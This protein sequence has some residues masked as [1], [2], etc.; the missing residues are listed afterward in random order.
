MASSRK[1]PKNSTLLAR[2]S[3]TIKRHV[4]RGGHLAAG[5]SGGI[6]SVV[7]L[8]L[9]CRASRRGAF[10]LS[11]LH[12]NHQIHPAADAWARFC[13]RLCRTLGVALRV[14]KVAVRRGNSLEAAARSARYAAFAGSKADAIVLAHNQDDQ[15]ETLLLQLLRGSGVKG[16]SAM[17][18]FRPEKPALLRPLLDVPRSEIAAY[19][20]ARKLAWIEDDSN[21]DVAFDRN[22][23]RHCVMPVLAARFPAY[24]RTLARASRHF[25]EATL[26]ADACA[27]ADAGDCAQTLDVRRLHGLSPAR[28]KNALRYFLAQH[29]VLMP[30]AR[31]L[32]ECARQALLGG[33]RMRLRL[34]EVELRRVADRLHVVGADGAPVAFVPRQWRGE[35]ALRLP[36]LGGVLCMT[37]CRGGGLSLV[38][39][40]GAAVTLR[41]RAGGE[42]LRPVAGR[43]RRTLKNLWQEARVP[44]WLRARVPLLFVGDELA[45]VPGLGI[46][47]AFQAGHAERGLM[48]DWRPDPG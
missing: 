27:A 8:D 28:V 30:N 2:V 22:Y 31:R 41:L 7:L 46:D 21:D 44:E 40:D 9:L 25:A 38:R 10:R 13:R 5:L 18:E 47:A 3:A 29:H 16:A 48:P 36:E 20:R 12:V 17:P 24:R 14:H 39:L 42:R 35:K 32:E 1:S 23:V 15:A 45:Y 34:G 26:L 4:R 11:A 37:A 6:D 33:T 19:A 43:P